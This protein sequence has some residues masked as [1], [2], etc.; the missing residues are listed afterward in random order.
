MA[1]E[2]KNKGGRPVKCTP[3]QVAQAV[4]KLINDYMDNGTMPTDYRL[5]KK[6]GVQVKTMQRWY[7]GFYDEEDEEPTGLTY[8]EAMNRLVEFR[9]GICVEQIASGASNK[10][11]GWIFLSKQKLWG[12]FQDSVQR[13]ET[14]G[15]QSITISIAGADGKPLKNGK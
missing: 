10:V 11:T 1:E 8:Q 13:T 3:E 9:R 5:M 4:D 15:S 12:G 6:L 14:K 7:D 2:K